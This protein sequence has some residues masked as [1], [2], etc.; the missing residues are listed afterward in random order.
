MP[1]FNYRNHQ[2]L[3]DQS[4]WS[5]EVNINTPSTLVGVYVAMGRAH[6]IQSNGRVETRISVQ[7]AP[8]AEN[9]IAN[10]GIVHPWCRREAVHP[11][12]S[13][14]LN[15][16]MPGTTSSCL[17]LN[18]SH[19]KRRNSNN[20]NNT[21]LELTCGRK[22]EGKAQKQKHKSAMANAIKDV[23]EDFSMRCNDL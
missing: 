20:I 12:P 4:R 23:F 6:S 19:T 11:R 2:Q 15:T 21:Y 5:V 8:L 7:G 10:R 18:N 22:L 13:P 9:L 3:S 16:M 14:G 17:N 1:I